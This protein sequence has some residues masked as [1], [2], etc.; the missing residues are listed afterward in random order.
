M[1]RVAGVSIVTSI[2]SMELRRL[3]IT[4]Y[5]RVGRQGITY[6]N[7]ANQRRGYHEPT[8]WVGAASHIAQL[9]RLFQGRIKS[10]RSVH[11]PSGFRMMIRK[12]QGAYHRRLAGTGVPR[13]FAA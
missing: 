9:S 7:V 8:P 12:E 4:L 13:A 10:Q 1:A 11:R 2:V 3:L 6:S 5:D